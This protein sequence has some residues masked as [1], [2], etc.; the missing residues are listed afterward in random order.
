MIIFLQIVAAGAGT[1]VDSILESVGV[2]KPV[3]WMSW[4]RVQ[5]FDYLQEMGI[6]PISGGKYSG[7]ADISGFF[8][9]LGVAK[10]ADWEVLSF[11]EKRVFVEL[12][13][14]K[15]T[16]NVETIA[17]NK[18]DY[19]GDIAEEDK[20]S[21]KKFAIAFM[22]FLIMLSGFFGYNSRAQ[23]SGR[24]FAFYVL[25]VALV[26]IGIIFPEKEIF[27]AMGEWAERV[28]V[29]LLMVKPVSVIFS[30]KILSRVVGFRKEL[31]LASFWFFLVH[32]VGLIIVKDIEFT[33]LMSVP[34]LTWGLFAGVVMVILGVTSNEK[35]V[36]LLKRNWKRIQYLAYFALFGTLLHTS[37]VAGNMMK[38]YVV[39]GIFL[40]LKVLEWSGV[41]FS[42]Q[43]H[44]ID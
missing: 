7:S 41:R 17:L 26:L 19:V 12:A 4:D 1:G 2:D 38:F 14:N 25:P 18:P 6:Y 24:I 31:G 15:V 5:K 13:Q 9:W 16:E 29:F 20:P 39:F 8:D 21:L 30:S 23:K 37:L 35:S 11:E 36:V 40:V 3:E 34:F 10:P 43:E 33:D 44:R 22:A 42:R 27:V 32:A 28:L